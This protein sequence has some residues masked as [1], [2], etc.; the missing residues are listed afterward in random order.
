MSK[1]LTGPIRLN[2]SILLFSALIIAISI[3]NN[4]TKPSVEA[5]TLYTA[6][7]QG[8]PELDKQDILAQHISSKFNTPEHVASEIV[9]SAFA[10]GEEQDV[11]PL[12]ILAVVQTE[13]SFNPTAKSGADTGLMQVNT[14]WQAE[15][16]A[17]LDRPSQLVEPST[18][19][20]IGTEILAKYIA[21]SNGSEYKGLRRYNG[22]GKQ[23]D[24]PSKVLKNKSELERVL[25]V[26][27]NSK[28]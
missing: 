9:M 14:Y 12:L 16:I 10:Q 27:P 5:P 18:N 23:N 4:F 11:D 6:F 28:T 20:K 17:K 3:S 13:S 21:Q 24:Y 1:P 19:I 8:E 15:A 2:L 25:S 7:F 22:L 26:E